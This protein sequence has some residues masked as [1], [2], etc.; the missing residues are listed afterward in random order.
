MTTILR[1]KYSRHSDHLCDFC[2]ERVIERLIH[3]TETGLILCPGCFSFMET[4]PISIEETLE[5][6]LLGNVV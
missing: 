3:Q 1:R 6:F 4:L 2:E 5:R